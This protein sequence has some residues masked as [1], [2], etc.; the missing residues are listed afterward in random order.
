MDLIEIKTLIEVLEASSIH[1]LKLKKDNIELMLEKENVSQGLLERTV[2]QDTIRGD[3]KPNAD[4]QREKIVNS[5][6]VVSPIVGVYYE[7]SS[8]QDEPFVKIGS[9][10]EQGD[11]VCI[12]EAMKV[13]NEIKAPV[14]GEIKAIHV[15]NGEFISYDQLLIEIGE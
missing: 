7:A 9:R 1:K 14:S 10:I 5:V 15:K 12:I 2:S 13:L 6:S 11:T 4:T 3:E 8:A